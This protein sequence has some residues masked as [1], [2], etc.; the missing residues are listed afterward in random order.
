[1]RRKFHGVTTLVVV[2]ISCCLATGS[3]C[4][5]T[6]SGP[7]S[8]FAA[9]R[10]APAPKVPASVREFLRGPISQEL[11]VDASE[12]R[13]VAAPDGGSWDITPGAKGIC[14]FVES[15]QTGTCAPMADAL[16]GRLNIQFVEPSKAPVAI[17]LAAPRVPADTPRFQAGLLPDDSVST[18]AN[19]RLEGAIAARP[20]RDGLYR[21]SGTGVIGQVTLH[22]LGR[23]SLAITAPQRRSPSLFAPPKAH[24]AS[25]PYWDGIPPYHSNGWAFYGA[26]WGR[27]AGIN[28]VTIFSSDTN[29]ICGNAQNLDGSWAGLYFCTTSPWGN[30]HVYNGAILRRGYA[31]PGTP[32][33]SVL[34][35]AT[36]Y[37]Q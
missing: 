10:H 4:A 23:R 21:L 24:A 16:A 3:A 5:A 2:A 35:A 31:G 18:T 17:D 7:Q 28:W 11:G 26:E 12:T 22:R 34:G 9:L 37:Y 33:A 36:Q 6:T 8:R 14:L 1:M 20:N 15:E 27:W 29:N 13:R 25:G 32:S 30:Q 19:A